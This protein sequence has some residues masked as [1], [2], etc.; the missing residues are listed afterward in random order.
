MFGL[1]VGEII[2]VL[3][4]LVLL[5]GA[6]RIPQIARGLGE[7]IRNF[8]SSIKEGAEDQDQLEDGSRK[9]QRMEDRTN[10]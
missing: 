4:L 3:A 5:F 8:R 7:G 10:R 6:K 1:G 2:L 9:N